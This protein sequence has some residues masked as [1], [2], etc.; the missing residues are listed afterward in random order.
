MVGLR[1]CLAVA[2][3]A[4]VGCGK[5]DEP[6]VV[7][8]HA[9][10]E[11]FREATGLDFTSCGVAE[12]HFESCGDEDCE[13]RCDAEQLAALRCFTNASQGCRPAH[14]QTRTTYGHLPGT[15]LAD[16]FLVPAE[17]GCEVI[18]FEDTRD[19]GGTCQEVSR[20]TCRFPQLGDGPTACSLHATCFDSETVVDDPA[21]DCW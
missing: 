17:V 8:S 15:V 14:L 6:R 20:Q 1:W 18:F 12:L 2:L 16:Y 3:V 19:L 7:E 10:I 21:S 5:E 4:A 13:G 11:A 9:A